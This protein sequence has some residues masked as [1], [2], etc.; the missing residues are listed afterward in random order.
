MKEMKFTGTDTSTF[1]AAAHH[2]LQVNVRDTGVMKG[3]DVTASKRIDHGSQ[4]FERAT[5]PGCRARNS[6]SLCRRRRQ[7]RH[8]LRTCTICVDCGLLLYKDLK[9]VKHLRH[10]EC[11]NRYHASQAG[12]ELGGGK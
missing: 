11:R 9:A 3:L 7:R 10:Y 2:N 8:V 6:H 5:W 12:G 1:A 4:S